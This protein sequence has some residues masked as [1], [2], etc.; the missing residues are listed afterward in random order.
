LI[1]IHDVRK[2][3]GGGN[4][5]GTTGIKYLPAGICLLDELEQFRPLEFQVAVLGFVPV[6]GMNGGSISKGGSA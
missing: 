5:G 6:H 4:V 2:I 3:K 1:Y